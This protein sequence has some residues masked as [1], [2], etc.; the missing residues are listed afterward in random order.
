MFKKMCTIV[1]FSAI[2]VTLGSCSKIDPAKADLKSPC[3]AFGHDFTG[4]T[5]CVKRF[6]SNNI[7]ML[8]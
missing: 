2:A 4:K 6:P 3:A 7:P 1:I 5:P 8:G